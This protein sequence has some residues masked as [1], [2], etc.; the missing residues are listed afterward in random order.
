MGN[1]FHNI[2][3]CFLILLSFIYKFSET[4]YHF[5]TYY[6]ITDWCLE[7]N[8]HICVNMDTKE[9]LPYEGN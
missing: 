8:L 2:T 9:N 3:C 4:Q 7:S 6:E 1:R 5:W